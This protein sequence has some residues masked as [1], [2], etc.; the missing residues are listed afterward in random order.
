[1][2]IIYIVTNNVKKKMKVEREGNLMRNFINKFLHNISEFY[3]SNLFAF[4]QF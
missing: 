1:M 4:S 3:E 2:I